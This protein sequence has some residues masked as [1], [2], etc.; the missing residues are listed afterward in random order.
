MHKRNKRIFIGLPVPESIA[1][2]LKAIFCK[3][4]GPSSRIF[5]QFDEV[6]ICSSNGEAHYTILEGFF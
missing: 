2:H 6:A 4:T 5:Y 1:K 3:T